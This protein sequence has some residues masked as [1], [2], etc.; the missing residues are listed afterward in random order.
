MIYMD[1]VRYMFLE[2][3]NLALKLTNLENKIN[4]LKNRYLVATVDLYM[5]EADDKEFQRVIAQEGF[6][7]ELDKIVSSVQTNCKEI[8]KEYKNIKIDFTP[9]RIEYG[10]CCKRNMTVK[11]GEYICSICSRREPFYD[12]D[13]RE[14]RKLP[15]NHMRHFHKWMLRIQGNESREE[16]G[17]E[18]DPWGEILLN[19]IR[20]NYSDKLSTIYDV[21]AAL[22]KMKRTNLNKNA[23]LIFQQVTDIKPPEIPGKIYQRIQDIFD[24]IF[25]QKRGVRI[26]YPFYIYQIIDTILPE[27]DS[28]RRILEFIP[29][30]S[31]YTWKKNL[32]K[33]EEI[34]P[35]IE[36]MLNVER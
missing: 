31:D 15:F 2:K 16:I 5:E 1:S 8:E 25:Q 32:D 3:I 14:K 28:T 30:Q 11:N 10:Y 6:M 19:D 34:Y 20:I 29:K 17:K 36:Y 24:K 9:E 23:S 21:R 35:S 18:S 13:D 26:Y 7:N 33:W 12:Y 4:N 27:N 22:K